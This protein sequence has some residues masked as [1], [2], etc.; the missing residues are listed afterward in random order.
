MTECLN[1]SQIYRILTLSNVYVLLY[2]KPGKCPTC[3]CIQQVCL[4]TERKCAAV[5]KL[6]WNDFRDAYT[7]PYVL[8][9]CIWVALATCGY[10][11]VTNYN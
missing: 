5:A 3:S 10:N 6:L 2:E 11:Q 1:L 8:K 7:N 9:M 4:F